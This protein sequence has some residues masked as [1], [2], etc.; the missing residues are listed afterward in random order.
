V[1]FAA[2]VVDSAVGTVVVTTGATVVATVVAIVVGTGVATVT[3][4][5]VGTGVGLVVTGAAVGA[6]CVQPLIVTRATSS[7]KKPINHFIWI[8][9]WMLCN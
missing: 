4:S 3:C 8:K 9:W 5:V 6:G 1:L 7:T 2:G